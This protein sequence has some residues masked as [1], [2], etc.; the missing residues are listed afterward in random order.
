VLQ[1]PAVRIYAENWGRQGDIGVVAVVEGRDAGACW[2]RVMPPGIGLASVDGQTPQ[3]GIAVRPEFQRRGFGTQLMQETLERAWRA[4]HRQVALT[5]HPE[6]PAIV[7]YERCGF[8]RVELRR[9][10]HLMVAISP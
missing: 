3:V 5:V 1:L 8:K 7:C 4:G 10:Y 2:M 9:G 6:N